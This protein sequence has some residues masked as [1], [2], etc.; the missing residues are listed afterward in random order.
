MDTSREYQK[1]LD[2]HQKKIPVSY[3]EVAVCIANHPETLLKYIS[4]NDYVQVYRLLHE[5]TAPMVIGKN[6]TFTPDKKRVEGELKSLYMRKDFDTLNTILD[7]F[8]VN[9]Q[10]NNYTSNPELI[11]RMRE[12]ELL[13]TTPIGDMLNANISA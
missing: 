10:T 7:H 3:R 2:K 8:V 11:Q 4:D 12:I 5:S 1:V 9:V 6:A 13:K